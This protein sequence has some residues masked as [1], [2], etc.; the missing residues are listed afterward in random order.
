MSVT[1]TDPP[2]T[3]PERRTLPER[4]P[5]RPLV[6]RP[7]DRPGRCSP[8]SWA[9]GVF[10]VWQTYPNYDTYYP[11]L[12]G[13]DLAHGH[14]PDYSV[15]RWPDPASAVDTRR[16][17]ALAPFDG[18]RPPG[19]AAQSRRLGRPSSSDVPAHQASARPPRRA[20]RGRRPAHPHRH[21]SFFAL[22][23]VVDLPSSCSS[24]PPLLEI[25]T[26]PPRLA[27]DGA[28]RARRAAPAG[29][30]GPVGRLRPLARARERRARSSIKLR[31]AGRRRAGHLA[32]AGLDRDG[33]APVLLHLD[34][35]H[36]RASSGATAASARRS[37]TLPATRGR[38]TRSSPPASAASACSSRVYILR[39]GRRC[40]AGAGWCT[41]LLTFLMIAAAGLSVIPRDM[42]VPSLLFNICVAVSFI[43]WLLVKEPKRVHNMASGSVGR[44]A[45]P[46]RGARRLYETRL[47]ASCTAKR[48]SSRPSTTASRRSSTSR[49]VP[50][51]RVPPAHHAYD[52]PVPVVRYQTAR[53]KDEVQP[54][55]GRRRPP[56]ART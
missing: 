3:A 15:Y 45:P 13:Q 5:T 52:S 32:R 36:L 54:S 19:R 28:A 29:S 55:I 42:A 7:G 2:R 41:G 11:L 39:R 18:H 14:L 24:S 35:R 27:R 47:P 25:A 22:R 16:R 43:A 38:T 21:E 46:R 20:R 12:W 8:C 37:S 56:P 34:A 10:V 50:R 40:A 44:G 31:G 51:R 17:S 49:A 30:M 53:P 33:R 1:E 9:L 4:F 48:R 26:P 23:G 6:A